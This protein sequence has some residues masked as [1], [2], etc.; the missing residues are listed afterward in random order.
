MRQIFTLAVLF[1]T[2]LALAQQE[3]S[4]W[5]FGRNAGLKFNIDGSVTP[6]AD[7]QLNTNEGC[8]SIADANGNLLFYTDGR[9]VWD[10]NHLI[11][12]NGN[13]AAGTGLY[14]D[15]SSTQSGIIV[16]KPGN[17]DVYYIFTVDEPHHLNAT[18]YPDAFPGPYPPE[19]G[20][21]PFDD[22][23]RNNGLNY[24][25]VDL[26]Q[27]GTNGSEGDISTSITHLITYDTNP[28]GEQI[29]F[30]CSEKITAVKNLVTDE[31]WVITHFLDRFYAFRVSA[32]GV[33]ATP[34]V[35]QIG[36]L[37]TTLG[38]RR[39]SIGYM[40]ASPDGGKLA[41]V[42]E[43]NGTIAGGQSAGTG[44]VLLY[45]FD[46]TTGAISGEIPVVSGV[47]PYGVEFSGESKKLYVTFRDDFSGT[48][49]LTQYNLEAAN[50]AASEQMI[51][52]GFVNLFAL[53]LAPNGKIY[54]ATPNMGSLG[55]V[56]SPENDGLACAYDNEGQPLAN[57]RFA[58][59][60]LPPFI[61]SF[62]NVAFNVEDL[63][64]GETAEFTMTS[65]QGVVSVLWDFGDGGTST[66]FNPT[67]NFAAAGT[68]TVTLTAN[69]A[70][71]TSVKSREIT[72]SAVPVA[73]SVPNEQVCAS[74][75][76]SSFD[77]S[78][79]DSI[80]L[81]SQAGFEVA[82][83][84]SSEQAAANSGAFPG[85]V[86]LAEGANEIFV[87]VFNPQNP[88]CHAMTSFTVTAYRQPVANTPTNYLV[89]DDASNDGFAQ[90]DLQTK[91]S[92][93]LAAQPASQFTV[94]YHHSLAEAQSN[95]NAIASPYI[96]TAISEPIF[97]RV[98][99]VSMPD[100]FSIA[101]F[102]IGVS[103]L[104]QAF[105]LPDLEACD[106]GNDGIEMFDLGGQRSIALGTQ[107]SN[108][109]SV[110]F[111]VSQ[112]DAELA[113]NPLSDSFINALNPQQLFARVTNDANAACYAIT[114]FN[115]LAVRSP[116]LDLPESLPLCEGTSMMLD[117]PAGFDTYLWSTGATTSS[118]L[119][120]EPGN[121][122]VTVSYVYNSVSCEA[123]RSVAIE[124]SNAATFTSI[125]IHDWT[126][127]HNSISVFVSGDGEYEYSLDGVHYQ[128]SNE[129]S[130]LIPGEYTVYV[131]DTNGC[132][133]VWETVF[134]LM[135]PKFFT[136]NGDG[137]NDFW[138]IV[139]STSEPDLQVFIY[140]RYGK[141]IASVQAPDKGWDG[142]YNG[143]ELPS[144]DYWFVAKRQ[145]GKEYKGHFSLK[146]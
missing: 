33:D 76:P 8:S 135:Y 141:L 85:S 73:N 108:D 39:N 69:S 37:I 111:Y 53:Q 90:F 98:Q 83:F 97:A 25:E 144:T 9:T 92:E 51:F 119:V 104:P 50:V 126:D 133:T 96:N 89:C 61:T 132:G 109:F 59:L 70:S 87:K 46:M 49:A 30:K 80:A 1:S 138:Q 66:D 14:G 48:M 21:I 74:A 146:R 12:P 35:S 99:N 4:V 26:S 102:Q 15:P 118:I 13:Y 91:S 101:Q 131:T 94:S 116:E 130:G 106:I 56:N 117:A 28:S 27:T 60:G 140:D 2:V 57:G 19:G 79:F 45:S 103:T 22:D 5:Y 64:L 134:L 43:E 112:Q 139:S 88:T 62:F 95:S 18:T 142:R 40:K 52:E 81:G 110:S 29:K 31:Y 32:A 120:S 42:H 93:I 16:P 122:S 36:P 44:V 11:M 124:N 34:V 121:Y 54:C 55:V 128:Q 20:I 136:P 77:L 84:P 23:G 7:G 72:I 3:A 47:A 113:N 17:P 38:Y 105:P 129:F 58:T 127:N 123:T 68:Y 41:V 143:N 24:T 65:T 75:F 145:N 71:D 125:E 78:A 10:R 63:C 67:H 115:V 82:Y 107:S 137:E 86:M 114:S 6:L 100:C